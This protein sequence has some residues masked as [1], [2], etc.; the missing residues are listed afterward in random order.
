[1]KPCDLA[2]VVLVG[3]RVV[4]GQALG[5][6]GGG[7]QG[8]THGAAR[9]ERGWQGGPNHGQVRDSAVL[10]SSEETNEVYGS[11]LVAPSSPGH[12]E[13]LGFRSAGSGGIK[14]DLVERACGFAW[15]LQSCWKGTTS[16]DRCSFAQVTKVRLAPVVMVP[17]MRPRGWGRD[18]YGAR[19]FGRGDGG[20]GRVGL[21]WYRGGGTQRQD[22]GERGA[23]HG[24]G[25]PAQHTGGNQL[26]GQDRD[27]SNPC[28]DGEDRSVEGGKGKA[29][30][31]IPDQFRE[32]TLNQNKDAGKV[33]EVGESSG[34]QI[35]KDKVAA[36][37]GAEGV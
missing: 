5:V 21:S 14:I 22:W 2:P 26:G 13:T 28:L 29:L 30:M 18:F 7:P 4:Q 27:E 19:R 33:L 17:P 20:R 8:A 12:G 31:D 3:A 35:N 10:S 23:A 37:R 16:R 9:E 32:G 36:I 25:R 1:V 6:G 15:A 24:R 34:A 11:H